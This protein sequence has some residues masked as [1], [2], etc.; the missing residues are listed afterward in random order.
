MDIL[1]LQRI[2]IFCNHSLTF[3]EPYNHFRPWCL[4]EKSGRGVP[5][6]SY[7]VTLSPISSVGEGREVCCLYER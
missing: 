5:V 7:G 4:N 2:G 6:E 3:T 1:T